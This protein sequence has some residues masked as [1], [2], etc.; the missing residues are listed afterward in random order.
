MKLKITSLLVSFILALSFINVAAAKPHERGAYLE[1]NIGTNYASFHFLGADYSEFD[2][3]GVNANL[4][5]QFFR[6]LALET[7]VTTYNRGLIGVDAV[8]KAIVPLEL[9]NNDISLFGKIGPAYV[10]D[11]HGDS[12]L[13]YLGL[14]AAYAVTPNL[15]INVQAQG[16]TVGFASLGLLSAGLTYHFG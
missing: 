4:G 3:V 12:L 2:S 9:G 6:Y 1:G 10:T 5:Y 14:G 11:G 7:G 15:D 8:L 16:V 13:P